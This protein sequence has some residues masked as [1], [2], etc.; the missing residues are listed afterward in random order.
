M[1]MMMVSLIALSA[2]VC[3]RN[4]KGKP[5]NETLDKAIISFVDIEI[6]SPIRIE[7]DSLRSYFGSDVITR[8]IEDRPFLDSLASIVSNLKAS[9][10]GF[11]P[12]TRMVVELIYSSGVKVLCMSSVALQL[13]EKE[14]EFEPSLLRLLLSRTGRQ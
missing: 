9:E 10:N 14:M 11:T 7:C 2:V 1:R 3:G 6:E 4:D 8:S 13:D 5:T 12:D